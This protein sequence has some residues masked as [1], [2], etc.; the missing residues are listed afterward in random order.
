MNTTRANKKERGIA[1]LTAIMALLLLSAVAASMLYSSGLELGIAGNYRDKQVATY[2]AISAL[3]EAKDRIQPARDDSDPDKIFL[4]D[5]LPSLAHPWIIYVVNPKPDETVAPWN[6]NNTFADTDLCHG[7]YS[8]NVLGLTGTEGVPCSGSGSLPPSGCTPGTTGCWYSVYNN[9]SSSYTGVFKQA[10]PLNYKWMRIMLKADNMTPVPV[11][12][13]PSGT[14]VCWDGHNQMPLPAGYTA[15]CMPVGGL[16]KI[17]VTNGGNGYDP[18]NP[19]TITIGPPAAGGTQAAAQAVITASPADKVG[20]VSVT[21]P[22]SAYDKAPTVQLTGGGGSGATAKAVV[23]QGPGVQSATLNSSGPG[24]Y[25]GSTGPTLTVSGG[26][27]G[28]GATFNV[29]MTAGYDCIAA[30][31]VSISSGCHN[32]KGTSATI[33]GNGGFSGTVK[34]SSQ[35]SVGISTAH[36][37]NPGSGITTLAGYKFDTSSL[38]NNCSLTIS[39]TPGYSVQ[40]IGVTQHGFNYTTAPGITFQQPDSGTPPTATTTLGPMP[41]TVGQIARIDVTNRG[42]GYTSAPTVVITPV[43]NG[44]GGAAVAALGQMGY[45]SAINLTNPG[46]HYWKVPTVTVGTPGTGAAG[47]AILGNTNFLS[48]VVSITA[49]AKTPLGTRAMSQ[50]EVAAELRGSGFNLG[51]ALTLDG[52]SPDFGTPQSNGFVINGNDLDS[53]GNGK[54][55]AHPAIGVYDDPNNPTNPTA[56][57]T[58]IGELGK[59][60]NYIGAHTAPDVENVFA[61]LGDKGT[62]PEGVQA[63][64]DAVASLADYPDHYKIGNQTD[65]TVDMGAPDRPVTLYIDGDFTASGSTHG[66]GILLVTGNVVFSGNWSW[67]GLILVIGQ[68]SFVANGGGNGQINGTVF[69]AKTKGTPAAGA[70]PSTGTLLDTLGSPTADFQGGGGNGIRYDHCLADAYMAQIPYVPPP[71]SKPLRVLSVHTL[72]Y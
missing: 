4:P 34:F 57:S 30:W 23:V 25:S 41:S 53:C 33:T 40:S 42:S 19:P 62:T 26:G 64:A 16:A 32:L 35:G 71:S 12:T 68:G 37:D 49:M 20:S 9:A 39:G 52:P 45:V 7:A 46:S 13:S 5:G 67:D 27:G 69:I 14:Q 43:S 50:M 59:P 2:A 3:Q 8:K 17:N 28:S 51:G 6:P 29:G 36:I 18:S 72:S 31:S 10:M 66:Y 11:G 56:L 61:S 1:L 55:P 21:N 48:P 44:S 58:V 38:G 65:S 60:Q 24:C 70:L 54:V 63:V 47:T 15:D 22:G